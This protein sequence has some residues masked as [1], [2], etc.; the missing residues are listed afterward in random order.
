MDEYNTKLIYNIYLALIKDHH[1]YNF[2][3]CGLPWM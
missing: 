2:L 3:F 1:N